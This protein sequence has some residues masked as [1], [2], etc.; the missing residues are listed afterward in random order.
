M[1]RDLYT[2]NHFVIN[3]RILFWNIFKHSWLILIEKNAKITTTYD[4][5]NSGNAASEA[6]TG[7]TNSWEK[8][9]RKSTSFNII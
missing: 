1:K 6:L 2:M 9:E 5:V 4:I 7:F 8:H 3:E